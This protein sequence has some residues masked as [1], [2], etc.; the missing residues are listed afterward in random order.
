MTSPRGRSHTKMIPGPMG[1]RAGR[2]R[3]RRS[4][5]LPQPEDS[6]LNSVVEVPVSSWERHP[7]GWRSASLTAPSG[8][9]QQAL[10]IASLIE[11]GT[12]PSELNLAEAHGTGTAL[13]T[14]SK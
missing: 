6:I 11:A 8:Q 4:R 9:A 14:P 3:R 10:L 2:G 13:G 12:L 5:C 7:A 1:S